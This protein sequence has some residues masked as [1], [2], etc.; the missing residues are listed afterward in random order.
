MLRLFVC[1]M[2]MCM[3][4]WCTWQCLLACLCG[5]VLG[6]LVDDYCALCA[7]SW[8]MSAMQLPSLLLTAFSSRKCQCTHALP[9][10]RHWQDGVHGAGSLD[11]CYCIIACRKGEMPT[12]PTAVLCK[13]PG[14]P[15]TSGVLAC[16]FPPHAPR[17][18]RLRPTQP[19]SIHHHSSSNLHLPPAL[20]TVS[21][22]LPCT[23]S[24][25][26]ERGHPCLRHHTP[27]L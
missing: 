17:E 16:P 19:Q 6:R 7:R 13:G 21:R 14:R 15:H 9:A 10:L 1:P 26:A 4:Q 11:G 20:L 12:A 24:M 27:R 25:H 2:F 3:T 8:L 22:H 5:Y 23:A 18:G